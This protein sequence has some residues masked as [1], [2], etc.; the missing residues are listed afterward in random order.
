MLSCLLTV[1]SLLSTVTAMKP[2][3]GDV[4]AWAALGVSIIALVVATRAQWKA[5]HYAGRSAVAAEEAVA[6]QRRQEAAAAEASAPRP[7]LVLERGPGSTYLLRNIGT[8][9]AVDV[10]LDESR[11]PDIA[12]DVP[13][14]ETLLPGEAHRMLLAGSMGSPLPTALP[15]K[16]QGQEDYQMIPMPPR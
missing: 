7:E 6:I 9:P 10:V 15:V 13:D 4:A 3:W 2:D 12:R 8:A 1:A 11:V 16:W 5:N 14:G